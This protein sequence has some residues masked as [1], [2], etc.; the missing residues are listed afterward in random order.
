MWATPGS[1]NSEGNSE[2][3]L[4]ASRCD[5]ETVESVE[6]EKANK[7]VIYAWLADCGT[8]VMWEL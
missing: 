3:I 1:V 2:A 7:T 8:A 6:P 4:K 5:L